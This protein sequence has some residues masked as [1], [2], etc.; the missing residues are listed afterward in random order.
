M[1]ERCPHNRTEWFCAECHPP[2]HE[3]VL[4]PNAMCYRLVE[5]F[6]VWHRVR[7]DSG[8]TARHPD[9]RAGGQFFSE[10]SKSRLLAWLLEGRDP[11]PLPP[12]LFL[13]GPQHHISY[14]HWS[15]TDAPREVDPGNWLVQHYGPGLIDF[16]GLVPYWTLVGR[17]GDA[18]L[19]SM[20]G[21]LPGVWR[22]E[23]GEDAEG[24]R[25]DPDTRKVT[26]RPIPV[27]DARLQ[28]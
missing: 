15:G 1:K 2:E 13:S 6:R 7:D 4:D 23:R 22:V 10:M 9:W 5:V 18:W 8:Y 16:G 12:P 19:L 25:Y 24:T 26:T 17:D 11:L 28:P 27:W 3:P 21:R 20:P 14:G